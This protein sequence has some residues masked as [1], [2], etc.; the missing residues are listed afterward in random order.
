[1]KS[2]EYKPGDNMKKN[3][4]NILW[5]LAFVLLFVFLYKND[6]LTQEKIAYYQERNMRHFYS[7]KR[8]DKAREEAINNIVKKADEGRLLAFLKNKIREESDAEAAAGVNHVRELQKKYPQVKGRIIVDGTSI[9]FPVVQGDDNEFYLD[10]DYDNSYYI[11]GGVF[12]DHVHQGDFSDQNTVIYGHNV[13]IGYIFH[14]LDKFRDKNFIK[15]HS[16][17]IIDTPLARR[18]FEVVCAMDVNMDA[19]Y[20]FN[21]YD[22]DEFKDYL[23]LISDNNILENRPLPK[24]DDKLITLS[25]CSDLNDRYAIVAVE[26]KEAYV[27]KK[28]FNYRQ[29]VQ[30][31]EKRPSQEISIY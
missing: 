10:H 31:L 13:R 28:N 5:A 22:D 25:T 16:E 24:K 29:A 7:S 1:M 4:S 8:I 3:Y 9:D 6:R 23:K 19:D 12:I 30:S 11:N 17:I 27:N 15:K 21:F 14:D 20:R 2:V 18:V 26:K